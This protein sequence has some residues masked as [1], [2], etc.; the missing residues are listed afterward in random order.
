MNKYNE[1]NIINIVLSKLDFLPNHYNLIKKNK[2]IFIK[3]HYYTLDYSHYIISRYNS[4]GYYIK[5]YGNHEL[6]TKVLNNYAHGKDIGIIV[7]DILIDLK[8]KN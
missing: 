6:K 8:K 3:C 5:I 4:Q 2:K 7:T 1:R